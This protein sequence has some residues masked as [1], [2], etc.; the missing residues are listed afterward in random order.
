MYYRLLSD[1]D[2]FFHGEKFV[3]VKPVVAPSYASPWLSLPSTVL[4]IS[5]TVV[6]VASCVLV[7]GALYW[8]RRKNRISLSRRQE[9]FVLK[10]VYLAVSLSVYHLKKRIYMSNEKLS[11]IIHAESDKWMN[12]MI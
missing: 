11:L 3:I 6:V 7:G 5:L 1:C 4:G 10:S 9:R 2:F 8:W 12:A